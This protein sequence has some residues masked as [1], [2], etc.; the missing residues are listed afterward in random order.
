MK[1][2]YE[3]RAPQRPYHLLTVLAEKWLNSSILEEDQPDMPRAFVSPGVAREK[4]IGDE[5]K[6]L[7][8]SGVG[9]LVAEAQ[10]SE[11]VR[12]D[13]V[14]MPHGTWVKRGGAANQLTEDLVSTSG[15]MAA[16][17]STTVTIEP[18]VD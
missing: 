11:D 10:C 16:Y 2:F 3:E 6:I 18:K 14:V 9:E 15:D 12:D 1:T 8:R 13:T 4:G 7:I 5:S 17:Y